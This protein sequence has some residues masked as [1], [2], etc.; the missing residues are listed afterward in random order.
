[1]IDEEIYSRAYISSNETT[2]YDR[3]L[4]SFLKDKTVKVK[5][6]GSNNYNAAQVERYHGEYK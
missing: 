2:S 6:K 3:I 5:R 1:M 4:K